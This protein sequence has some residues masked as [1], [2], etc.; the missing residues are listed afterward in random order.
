MWFCTVKVLSD[1]PVEIMQNLL[2]KNSSELW[3]CAKGIDETNAVLAK[4]DV[5][6]VNMFNI[7]VLLGF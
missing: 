7:N 5:H 3:R 6:L 4:Q 1:I 2:G